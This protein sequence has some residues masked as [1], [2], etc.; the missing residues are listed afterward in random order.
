MNTDIHRSVKIC[1]YLWPISLTSSSSLAMRASSSVTRA[2]VR[3]S[4]IWR[5]M[6]ITRI[7]SSCQILGI[8]LIRQIREALPLPADSFHRRF[9][10]AFPSDSPKAHQQCEESG[11]GY[12]AIGNLKG[13]GRLD[14]DGSHD[15]FGIVEVLI[16]T[17]QI[18]VPRPPL[19]EPRSCSGSS[20]IVRA[21][22]ANR[23]D[24][25]RCVPAR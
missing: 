12:V 23:S 10:A 13:G 25:H 21:R 1:V 22:A 8:R 3:A 5:I 16:S 4:R 11:S 2:L 15:D 6:R 17:T 9:R 7:R 24:H 14:A 18:Q 20:G 19:R